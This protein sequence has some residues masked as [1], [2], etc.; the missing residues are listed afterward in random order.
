MASLGLHGAESMRSSR[1]GAG[2]GSAAVRLRI[3]E[4]AT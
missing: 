4:W 3:M 2:L 1:F